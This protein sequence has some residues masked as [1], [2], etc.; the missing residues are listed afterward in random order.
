M[1]QTLLTTAI[2][3]SAGL[4]QAVYQITNPY[5]GVPVNVVIMAIFGSF[6]AMSIADPIEPRKKMWFL[7]MASAFIG[8][9]SVTLLPHV[10]LMSWTTNVPQPVMGGLCGFIS[11]WAIPPIIEVI[12]TWVRFFRKGDK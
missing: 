7:V 4:G 8:V 12:P 3:A 6:V 2:G 11:R 5:L 1:K 10:P 9:L